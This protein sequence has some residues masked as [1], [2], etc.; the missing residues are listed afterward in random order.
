MTS[1][2]ILSQFSMTLSS[3][4]RRST[5]AGSSAAN[6]AAGLGNGSIPGIMPGSAFDATDWG[7]ALASAGDSAAGATA[8]LAEPGIVIA[9]GF[10]IRCMKAIASCAEK[11]GGPAPCLPDSSLMTLLPPRCDNAEARNAHVVRYYR[12]P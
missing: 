2:L 7:G 1:R 9:N 10:H 4:I 5:S 6:I 11:A 3:P 12:A 8:P